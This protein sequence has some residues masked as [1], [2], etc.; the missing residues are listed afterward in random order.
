MIKLIGLAGDQ[1][2][3]TFK[4]DIAYVA[5]YDPAT[6]MIEF[7]YYIENGLHEPQTPIPLGEGLTSQIIQSR[8]PLLLNRSSTGQK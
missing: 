5:L 6:R 2:A 3:A 1:M 7:P 4:A 8:Q